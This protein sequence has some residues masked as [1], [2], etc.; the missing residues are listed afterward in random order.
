MIYGLYL[1]LDPETFPGPAGNAVGAGRLPARYKDCWTEMAQTTGAEKDFLGPAGKTPAPGS[2]VTVT[3][4]VPPGV[5][6]VSTGCQPVDTAKTKEITR[7]S[8]RC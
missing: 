1:P 6:W 5:R 2:P 7:F 8:S 4:T 3:V